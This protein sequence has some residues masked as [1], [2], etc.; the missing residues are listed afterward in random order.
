MYVSRRSDSIYVRRASPCG[1]V[2]LQDMINRSGGEFKRSPI[3]DVLIPAARLEHFGEQAQLQLAH[4]A[5]EGRGCSSA[6]DAI[7]TVREKGRVC[8]L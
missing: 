1:G 2:V 6:G 5:I 4:D 3:R 8:V 7:L